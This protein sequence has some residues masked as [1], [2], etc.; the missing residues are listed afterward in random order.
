[1]W[2]DTMYKTEKNSSRYKELLA[3]VAMILFDPIYRIVGWIK[4]EIKGTRR[5]N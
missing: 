4:F 3:L 2:R 5:K 1:M